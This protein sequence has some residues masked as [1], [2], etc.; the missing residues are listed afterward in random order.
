MDE[1][2]EQATKDDEELE[3]EGSTSCDE[4]WRL[5]KSWVSDCR[6]TH[7]CDKPEGR[8]VS[9]I[10]P[11]GPAIDR[12]KATF[13]PTRLIHIREEANARNRRS[14][15]FQLKARLLDSK[16]INEPV[17]YCTLSHCWGTV[18]FLTLKR[19]TYRS[20][21]ADICISRLSKTFQ[22]ALFAANRLGFQ[23]VWID[24][25]CIIQKDPEDW[26]REASRMSSVY[27]GSSLNLAATAS[28]NG[29]GGLFFNRRLSVVRP[30]YVQ[31]PSLGATFS[32]N[33]GGYDR[34][35]FINPPRRQQEI[36]NSP[37]AQRGWVFQERFLAPRTLHFGATRISLECKNGIV[38]ETIPRVSPFLPKTPIWFGHSLNGVGIF[39]RPPQLSWGNIVKAYSETLLTEEQD[40]LIAL[41]G[42]ATH[43]QALMKDEYIAGLW[44]KGLERQLLWSVKRSNVNCAE[45]IPEPTRAIH[46]RAPSWSWASVNG[47]ICPSSW[48]NLP[49]ENMPI[50]ILST[51]IIPVVP[52]YVFGQ[53]SSASLQVKCGQLKRCLFSR[54][55]LSWADSDG[56]QKLPHLTQSLPTSPKS[57]SSYNTQFLPGNIL[58]H[59]EYIIDVDLLESCLEMFLLL[60]D[61]PRTVRV[62]ESTQPNEPFLRGLLLM[63]T[64]RNGEY[65]RTGY[66][67]IPCP[68]LVDPEKPFENHIFKAFIKL[69]GLEEDAGYMAVGASKS[70][71]MRYQISLV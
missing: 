64:S 32:R 44:R 42:I 6:L 33:P 8:D 62:N 69:P 50:R 52:E 1:I 40:K 70:E 59:I 14:S 9:D 43:F 19:A 26:A 68:E 71:A 53:L 31:L 67:Q 45:R 61:F 4:T 21:R 66:F 47:H 22:D 29:N 18:P 5:A 37:L 54:N 34:G 15:N 24:S 58:E 2:S 27:T 63:P 35:V 60:V 7:K 11:P 20:F 28:H 23:Y 65:Q 36:D 25:L 39:T 30:C 16:D 41:A 51:T 49:C 48:N 3:I 17:E 46:Y 57:A 13:L 12:P 55:S 56:S 10:F 38:C